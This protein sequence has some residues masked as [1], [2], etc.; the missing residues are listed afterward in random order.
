VSSTISVAPPIAVV[1]TGSRRQGL[2]EH[3]RKR[4]GSVF[5]WQ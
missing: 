4:F 5:G 2:E 3:D 1:T